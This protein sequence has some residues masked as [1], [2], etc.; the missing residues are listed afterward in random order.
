MRVYVLSAFRILEPQP[1]LGG[2]VRDP[3]LADYGADVI[4]VETGKYPDGR[5]PGDPGYGEVNRNKRSVT[6]NFQTPE[7]QD[8]L[9]A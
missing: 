8:L 5:Q 9:R 3:F 2:A 7:G 1:R 4:K 6:L